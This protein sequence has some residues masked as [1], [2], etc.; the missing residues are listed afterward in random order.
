MSCFCLVLLTLTVA[1]QT[2]TLK[3]LKDTLKNS[4]D[5]GRKATVPALAT[6]RV[7]G[8]VLDAA[9]GKPL[10]YVNVNF[11]G[12]PIG[13]NTDSLGKFDLSADGSFDK[14]TFSHMGYQSVVKSI[15]PGQENELHIT[16]RGSQTQLKG[17]TITSAKKQRYR[18]KDNPAV[19]LI[20]QIINHKEE[21][22]MEGADYLQYDQYERIG[23]SFFNL[24]QK[25][26]NGKFFSKYKFML[27]TVTKINGEKTTSLPVFFSEKLS[28]NYYRKEPSKTIQVL[29]AQKQIN[30]IKFIDTVGL[31]MYLNRLYGN[32]L[33]IYDNNIFIITN[34]FLSPIAN[35]A[36]N[37]YKFFIT[38]TINT[39]A[40]KQVEVSYTPRNKGDLLFE[41]KLLVTLDGHYAV[42]ACEMNVNKQINI[43]FMRSLKIK[44]NF[45]QQPGGRYYLS[46]SDV[47]ADF[48][49]RKATGLGVIGERT[50][51]YS[52]YKLS[53]PKPAEFYKGKDVQVSPNANQADTAYW[54]AHRTD[55]LA[56]Q[57][58]QLYGKIGKLEQMPSFKRTLWIASALTT[59]F[60]D[61]NKVEVGPIGSF[62]AFN[63]QE[64][65]RF[66]GAARTTPKFN[67][68]LYFEG[69]GAIGTKDN[70]FKYDAAAYLS[71][72]K[73]KPSRF[74]N[75]YFKASYLYDVDVPGHSFSTT[76]QQAAL[77]SF[78]TGKTDYWLYSRIFRLEYVKDFDSHLS[79]NITFKNWNQQPAALLVYQLNDAAGTV[80]HDLTTSEV[81]VHVR[82]APHEQMIQG[83]VYRHYIYSKYPIFDLQVNHGFKG[84]LNGSY[85]FT[86]IGLNIIKR[87]YTSQLGYSDITLLGGYLHGKVPFPLLNISPANQAIAYDADA[88][89]RMNYLEFVSD[90]YVGINFTHSFSGFFLNK[91]PL[92][93]HLKWREYLSAKIL[94]GGLRNENNPLYSQNLYRLPPATNGAYGTYVLGSTPYIEAGAGI[95]NIFKIIRFDF[96][97]RFNYLSHPGASPYGLKVSFNPDF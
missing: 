15:K 67:K 61:F 35:H 44:L 64:G 73:V 94:Y 46:K 82:Y 25:F 78:Q 19:S 71:L 8:Q 21:N 24:T 47:L 43:N 89:N 6:T 10:L 32:N 68:T 31:D 55:T 65:L 27:D 57:Q 16:M 41:G 91:I 9:T 50:V 75:D 26:I 62:F 20:Q 83:T 51:L 42:T 93:E 3:K 92:I 45:A 34:Q 28:E 37:Y 4:A 85:A 1:A 53:T 33:D 59:G 79:Y 30:I 14:V 36:P 60:A 90:H 39:P 95:G 80:V 76:A 77:A 54:A 22:R 74:P 18:N 5:T 63:S 58:A 23:L 29:N 11:N 97:K 48:G 72:N 38:D 70:V 66:Q 87:F 96:I 2:D 12:A 88:Y 52:N 81:D 40:G 7:S 69:Y 56:G 17:V 84:V 86:N 49:S 13:A